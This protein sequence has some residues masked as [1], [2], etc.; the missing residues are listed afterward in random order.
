[1]VVED[2]LTVCHFHLVSVLNRVEAYHTVAIDRILNLTQRRVELV[3]WVL[4][5]AC[6]SVP[7][8]WRKVLLYL[9]GSQILWAF[10]PLLA[11]ND[12]SWV[13]LRLIAAHPFDNENSSAYERYQQDASKHRQHN[14]QYTNLVL[15]ISVLD[16]ECSLRGTPVNHSKNYIIWVTCDSNRLR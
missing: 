7:G 1:M 9:L 11:L 16:G 15:N 12:W 8:H 6:K 10:K 4:F 13:N 2:V 5:L 14:D 3:S